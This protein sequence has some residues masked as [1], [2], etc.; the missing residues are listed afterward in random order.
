[1]TTPV[2]AETLV[3]AA[4]AN[5]APTPMPASAPSNPAEANDDSDDDEPPSNPAEANDDSD[6]DEPP[7]LPVALVRPGAI[8]AA[9]TTEHTVM[10]PTGVVQRLGAGTASLFAGQ[11][12]AAGHHTPH[13]L[14]GLAALV[15]AAADWLAGTAQSATAATLRPNLVA[16][17]TSH[18]DALEVV[19]AL[20]TSA[21]GDDGSNMGGGGDAA[22]IQAVARLRRATALEGLGQPAA[23]AADFAAAAANYA[24]LL[25]THPGHTAAKAG[26]ALA[27][28]R[29]RRLVQPPAPAAATA[30]APT[31]AGTSALDAANGVRAAVAAAVVA[32]YAAYL[33]HKAR[34]NERVRAGDDTGAAAAF[35]AAGLALRH[36][37]LWRLIKLDDAGGARAD[38]GALPLVAPAAIKAW[39]RLAQTLAQLAQPAAAAE[40]LRAA[41]AADPTNTAARADLAALEAALAR[42]CNDHGGGSGSDNG[43]GD[44]A[45]SGD[46]AMLAG[47]GRRAVEANMDA[48]ELRTLAR[49]Q[50]TSDPSFVC[51]TWVPL[52]FSRHLRTPLL[53]FRCFL[54]C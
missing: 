24:A 7:P 17:H 13:A 41:L 25:A 38:A 37:V 39:Y 35:S 45:N 11:G 43:S 33:A 1:M 40:Q 16:C 8:A 31:A 51:F 2:I 22:A 30:D 21:L 23:A 46:A 6:D 47:A 15:A 9:T 50:V 48:C 3:A 14:D 44:D 12:A 4:L 54:F 52:P 18:L 29:A 10:L 20:C 53:I 34:G 42:G 36:H 26:L 27:A 28:G 19:V 49:L 5:P 32:A